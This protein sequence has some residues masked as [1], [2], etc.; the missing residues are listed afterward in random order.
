MTA[1]KGA[2]KTFADLSQVSFWTGIGREVSST[3]RRGGPEARQLDSGLSD[4][5]GGGM[6]G[7]TGQGGTSKKLV[8][9]QLFISD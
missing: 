5:V 1:S 9:P 2:P 4:K 8:T 6:V 3:E 7:Q